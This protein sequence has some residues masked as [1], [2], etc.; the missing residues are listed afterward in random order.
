M[1]VFARDLISVTKGYEI[2]PHLTETYTFDT[3]AE[4]KD[5]IISYSDAVLV[6]PGGYGT[7]DEMLTV[8]SAKANKLIDKPIAIYNYK[9]YFKTLEKFFN[10]LEE[11]KFSKIRFD[12]IALVSEDL[13]KIL[14]YFRSYSSTTL[15]DKFIEDSSRG[16]YCTDS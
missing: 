15:A 3:L 11:K 12:E 13:D 6:L 16:L 1:G 7:I 9:G 10:E 5:K 4:R 8:V 2:Y 14:A